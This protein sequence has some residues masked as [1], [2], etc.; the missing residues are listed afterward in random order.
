MATK[1]TKKAVFARTVKLYLGEKENLMASSTMTWTRGRKKTFA[2]S[3]ETP[4]R[5][6]RATRERVADR[7]NQAHLPH[8][9][10][11]PPFPRLLSPLLLSAEHRNINFH[12]TANFTF[13]APLGLPFLILPSGLPP[14][15]EVRKEEEP[16]QPGTTHEAKKK[17]GKCPLHL[18]APR[19]LL[20]G[21]ERQAP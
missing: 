18:N 3:C 4:C 11:L 20:V 12:Q 19:S 17:A 6:L 8:L 2:C 1:M 15:T 10:L 9:P 14:P 13:P 5:C 16:S 7:Q 21:H